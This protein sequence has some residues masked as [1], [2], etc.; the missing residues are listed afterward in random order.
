MKFARPL[1]LVSLLLQ[2]PVAAQEIGTLTLVEGPLRVIRG[3]TVLQCKEGVRLRTGD[4]LESSDSGFAQLEFT[5]GAIVALGGSTR[6]LVVSHAGPRTAAKSPAELVL[7][8]GWLKGQTGHSG[9]AFRYDSPLLAA[10]TQNGSLLLHST[11]EEA[12]LFVESGSA[13]F[14][15]VSSDGN[16]H[17]PRIAQTEQFVSRYSGKNASVNPRPSQS[18][19]DGMPHQ[20]RDMLPSR[21]SRFTGK[22]PQ[23]KRD[24]EVSYAEIQPWLTIAPAL[25]R[26]FV[27]RFEPRLQDPAFRKTLE[28]H[29]RE[30]PEWGPVVHPELYEPATAGNTAPKR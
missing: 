14:G 7:L 9:D 17:N 20:F 25:R 2:L 28:A 12:D 13:R 21:V 23:P 1:L 10:T 6:V 22:P 18:F 19:V 15:E 27:R 3:T 8:S 4:I 11:A 29:L 26:G 16:W 24:H 30:H 5:G